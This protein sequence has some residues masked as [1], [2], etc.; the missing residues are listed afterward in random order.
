MTG[1]GYQMEDKM[2]ERTLIKRAVTGD[3]EA[4]AA[5]YMMYRDRLYRYAYFRLGNDDDAEDAVSACITS[6]F[7]DIY[8]LR[9]EKA[10]GSWIF[11]ILYRACCS[12]LSDRIAADHDGE[13][14]LESVPAAD[15]SAVSPE[16]KEAI[17]ILRDSDRDVV[18][19]SVVAGYNSR[20]IADIMSTK[21]ATVRSRL[22]RGL[23]KMREFLTEE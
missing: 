10:F 20:E 3:K 21:P 23:R 17:G 15:N 12:I 11:R 22:A 6:A 18:L 1:V 7:E 4:F 19:L 14:A 5:L 16:I 13:E 9:N 8:T 2:D